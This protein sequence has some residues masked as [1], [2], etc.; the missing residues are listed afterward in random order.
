MYKLATLL[1]FTIK[2]S[3]KLKE[4]IVKIFAKVT[5]KVYVMYCNIFYKNRKNVC[6]F[7]FVAITFFKKKC[8][9]FRIITNKY[10]CSW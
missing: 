5:Y 2:V 10:V 1:V 8:L 9:L 6:L 3:W 4:K 7:R